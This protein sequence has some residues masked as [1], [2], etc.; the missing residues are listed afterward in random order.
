MKY[1]NTV[2]ELVGG[3]VACVYVLAFFYAFAVLVGEKR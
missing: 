1:I 3:F 2:A